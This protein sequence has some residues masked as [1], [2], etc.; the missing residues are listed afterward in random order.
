VGEC[1]AKFTVDYQY[2]SQWDAQIDQVCEAHSVTQHLQ[3]VQQFMMEALGASSSGGNHDTTNDWG[4]C[5]RFGVGVL[6]HQGQ[7]REPARAAYHVRH[8][9]LRGR[10]VH[11]LGASKWTR[12]GTSIT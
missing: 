5:S 1:F 12:R 7:H 4:L 2:R 6:P 8:P 9:S 3:D 10:Q 11:H